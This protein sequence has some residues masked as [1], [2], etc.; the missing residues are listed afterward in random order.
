LQVENPVVGGWI[1]LVP[2][3]KGLDVD[4][5]NTGRTLG[6]ELVH[7]VAANKPTCPA[8]QNMCVS[9]RHLRLLPR[10]LTFRKLNTPAGKGIRSAKGD[11]DTTTTKAI[12]QNPPT[13]YFIACGERAWNR[14]ESKSLVP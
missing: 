4:S 6:E 9:Y 11:T 7:Q 8:N 3:V 1:P 5:A 14:C 13:Y 12:W 10:R 2:L